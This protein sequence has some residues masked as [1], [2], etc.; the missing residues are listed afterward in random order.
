MAEDLS[1]LWDHAWKQYLLTSKRTPADTALIQQLRTPEL[2]TARIEADHNKFQ[3]FRDKHGKLTSVLKKCLYPFQALSI[4]AA[5]GIGNSPAAPAAA[6][7]GAV[8]FVLGAANGVSEAYDWITELF[9]KLEDFTGRLSE[10]IDGGLKPH[11]RAKVIDIFAN[12]LDVL[13]IAEKA[14]KDKRWKK[15]GA[16]LFLGKDEEVKQ[17]LDRLAVL[18]EGEEKLV[19]AIN[20]ST[21]QKIAVKAD[22]IDEGVSNVHKELLEAKELRR[23]EQQK[24]LIEKHLQTSAQLKTVRLFEEL[25]DSTLASSGG[26]LI[27]DKQF[28]EWASRSSPLLAVSGGPGTGKSCLAS[29]AI[30]HLRSIYPQNSDHPGRTSVAYFFVKEHDQDLRDLGNIL[31]SIV[32]QIAQVDAVF[33][34]HVAAFLLESDAVLTPSK[35]W[36]RLLLEFYKGRDLPN[37]AVIVL[38]GLDEAPPDTLR[39]LFKFFD[40]LDL[41]EKPS[42]LSFACFARPEIRERIN[43]KLQQSLV[44]IE[45][46]EQNEADIDLYV[47]EHIKNIMIVREKMRVGKTKKEAHALARTVRKRVME[48]ADGMFFKVVLIMEQIRDKERISTVLSTIDEV[49]VQLEAMIAHVFERITQNEDVDI[50]DLREIL[51][52]VAFAKRPLS[53]SELYAVLK[54]RTGEPYDALL[55]RLQGRFASLFKLTVAAVDKVED[56]PEDAE[57]SDDEINFDSDEEDEGDNDADIEGSDIATLVAADDIQQADQDD[58]SQATLNQFWKTEVRFAHASIRDFVV[59]TADR[60]RKSLPNPV[61]VDASMADYHIASVSLKAILEKDTVEAQQDIHKRASGRYAS[62]APPTIAYYGAEFITSHL[63]SIDIA[64]LNPEKKLNLLDQVIKVF[65][66]EDG[67][68]NFL[69]MAYFGSNMISTLFTDPFFVRPLLAGYLQDPH[70]ETLSE[71]DRA[72]IKEAVAS[73]YTFWRP[74]AQAAAKTWLTKLNEEDHYHVHRFNLFLVWLIHAYLGQEVFGKT[75]KKPRRG[76]LQFDREEFPVDDPEKLKP[77]VEFV[78]IEKTAFWHATYA[79]SLYRISA[80]QEAAEQFKLAMEKKPDYWIVYTS[81]SDCLAHNG[82]YD[83]AMSILEKTSAAPEEWHTSYDITYDK[84]LIVTTALSRMDYDIAAQYSNKAWEAE[85]NPVTFMMYV[86]T[87]FGQHDFPAI[88]ELFQ[89]AQ[90]LKAPPSFLHVTHSFAKCWWELGCALWSQGKQQLMEPLMSES[91][92]ICLKP[93]NSAVGRGWVAIMA[94]Y[95]Y[96]FYED[97]T[98]AIELIEDSLAV[99]SANLSE[100]TRYQ[101]EIYL[102]RSI[103]SEGVTVHKAGN[104]EQEDHWISKLR[105]IATVDATVGKKMDKAIYKMNDAA[106]YLGLYLRIYAKAPEDD[107]RACFR[108]YILEAI[109][110]LGDDDPSNDEIAY[111][112]IQSVLFFTGDITNAVAAAA[113]PFIA[114][115]NACAAKGIEPFSINTTDRPCFCDGLCESYEVNSRTYKSGFEEVWTCTECLN[116]DFCERCYGLLKDGKLP[117]RR[118]SK[119]HDLIK[120]WPVPEEARGVAADFEGKIIKPRKEWVDALRK[121]WA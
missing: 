16:M 32:Y 96:T 102:A 98:R 111:C 19:A 85:R 70:M 63:K 10:Y 113:V 62:A 51:L 3:K 12:I 78:D 49:P 17:A 13:A 117:M 72:W 46:G 37:A 53:V 77:I 1:D 79:E 56:T 110:M 69:M 22:K 91:I 118:C 88:V 52:W 80:Y 36:K 64:S 61:S 26:W 99:K 50:D 31:K 97:T 81:C 82:H 89:T 87:L 18:F 38:D 115:E 6:V 14:V 7:F 24:A 25:M 23:L 35:I 73:P 107:W 83:E 4:I 112:N 120:V 100:I 44:I 68:R 55:S 90:D 95:M 65:S 8:Y 43:Y 67:L 114:H 103:Y 30:E 33:R 40:D 104:K 74:L 106:W 94:K 47:K 5:S 116:T 42:R 11:L 76:Y 66:H 29:K 39:G 28:I 86:S 60:R 9:N 93:E 108:D 75:G 84:L 21:T 92:E 105:K 101:M 2:L 45:I 121:V 48:K 27:Q 109:D 59:S 20:F 15:Y 71:E 57:D 58:L 54:M 41:E 119:D 34:S